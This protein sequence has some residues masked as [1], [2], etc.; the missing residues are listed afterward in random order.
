MPKVHR[1]VKSSFTFRPLTATGTDKF[2]RALVATDWESIKRDTSSETVSAFTELL[3]AH[4]E[5]CFPLKTRK[6]SSNDTP[7][8]SSKARRL[9]YRKRRIYKKEGKSERYRS[10]K[11]EYDT[12]L[13]TAK[14]KFMDKVI[15]DC[16]KKRNTRGYYKTVKKFQSK[17][18]PSPWDVMTLLPGKSEAEAAEIIAEFFN[19]ISQDYPSLPNPGRV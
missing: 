19:R 6:V 15:E 16:K 4:I 7:W 2:K 10:A 18:T 13:S 11:K 12:E 3:N 8:Y 5:E 17:E 9:S 1:A 14:K